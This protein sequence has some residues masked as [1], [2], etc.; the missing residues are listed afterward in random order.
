MTSGYRGEIVAGLGLRDILRPMRVY[1]R[2][3]IPPW[4]KRTG[5]MTDV[6]RRTTIDILIVTLLAAM[7]AACQR[8]GA[9]AQAPGPPFELRVLT[10][11]GLERSYYLWVPPS[12]DTGAPAPLVLVLHGGGGN[13][14]NVCQT[15]GGV[16]ALAEEEGFIV[17]CP[18]GVDGHWNDGRQ[19]DLYR[20]HRESIDD[21]AFL[22]ALVDAVAEEVAVDRNR[23]YVTGLSN[24]GMMTLRMACEASDTFAAAA[25]VI[26][27]L[28][29]DLTCLP[30]RPVPVMIMNG[31]QDP[32]MPWDGGQV[33]FW[34]RQL[35]AVRSTEATAAFWA[36]ADGCDPTPDVVD[37]PDSDP[38]DNTTIERRTYLG[39]DS[40]ASVV[41]IAVR[42]GGHTLPGGEQY[43]PSWLVGRVSHDLDG[44][45]AI[46][47][48]LASFSLP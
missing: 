7:C 41:L 19:I 38:S 34:R 39:C 40:A 46:W 24:G 6:G 26:A 29:S 37:L 23:V 22:K 28:P 30:A 14:G 32:L 5:G 31:T 16:A 36:S 18:A 20:A 3:S 13:P 45:L 2:E 17:A 25:A 15:T 21:V 35:G 48:F 44:A 11:N 47:D 42:G 4:G 33:H 8:Q 1:P 9:R 43:L 27:N 12:L 10:V